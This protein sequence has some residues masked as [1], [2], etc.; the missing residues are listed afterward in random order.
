MEE[1][2]VKYEH[3]N[4][5]QT[6]Y[7]VYKEAINTTPG[8]TE[9][10]PLTMTSSNVRDYLQGTINKIIRNTEAREEF[11]QVISE[12]IQKEPKRTSFCILKIQVDNNDKV[13]ESY[14][15]FSSMKDYP[16]TIS[17]RAFGILKNNY[18]NSHYTLSVYFGDPDFGQLSRLYFDVDDDNKTMY[19]FLSLD[20]AKYFCGCIPCVYL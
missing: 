18:S 17:K 1:A 14:K 3:V 16:F 8:K 7:S 6:I 13:I 20:K 15:L 2:K 12:C 9:N 4:K 10:L 11:F 19:I 5:K